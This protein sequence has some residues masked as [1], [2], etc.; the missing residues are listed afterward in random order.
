[1]NRRNF[2]KSAGA[3]AALGAVALEQAA[4]TSS[5]T[6]RRA[7]KP[8]H[9]ADTDS[10]FEREPLIRP[11]GFKGG[12]MTEI[13]QTAAMLQGASGTRKVGL[14]THSVLWSDAAVFEAHSP[15]GGNAI[16]FT[17]TE[18]ALQ[19][20]KGQT[21]ESPIHMVESIKDELW[22]YGKKIACNPNMRKTFVL[23]SLVGVDN[24]AWLLYAA[25]NG[26]T[27]FDDLIPE[28]YRPSL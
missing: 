22:E 17:M 6:G 28:A 21:F 2:I 14:C 12:F 4:C 3:I 24:A 5:G 25:E 23:N 8:L 11:F 1:M 26:I 7:L 15:A 20:I 16:M 19:M 27:K 10:N 9:I 18:R 13:W